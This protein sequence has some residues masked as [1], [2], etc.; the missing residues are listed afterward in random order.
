MSRVL[1]PESSYF[2]TVKLLVQVIPIVAKE[3]VFA[4]KG[5]TAINLFVR[6]FPR[7]SV[8]IDLA[9]LPLEPRQKAFVNAKA[10]LN[11]IA[12]DIQTRLKFKTT[13][14][15]NKVD[16]L[17]IMVSS[18]TA[19]I[20]IEVSPVARGTLHQPIVL[21]IQEIVENT[22]GY[23][24]IA[25]VSLP[26]LYGGKLCATLDRQHPRDLFDT[27]QLLNTDSIT[28]KIFVGFFTYVLSHS[29]PIH[30]VLSPHW[31]PLD[32]KFDQEFSGMTFDPVSLEELLAVQESVL[33][34]LK[35]HFT[36]QD[37]DFL[38]SFKRGKP[39]WDLFDQPQAA[40]LPA[41]RWKLQNLSTLA[42]NKEKHAEQLSKLEEVLDDWLASK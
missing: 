8:D 32:K 1:N 26:D 17:R 27:A 38:L 29:R 14:Q 33:P 25:V 7:L 11:R 37:R 4:L 18:P 2:H 20:K 42:Q 36:T 9:Y 30:E 12:R 22:F 15:D 13:L 41:I 3:T 10:A 40:E 16:E 34:A 39:N 24:E 31:Q 21:P 35:Q 28:R 23:A 19:N 6:K 5:G